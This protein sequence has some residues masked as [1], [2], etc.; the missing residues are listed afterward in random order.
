[1]AKG[2][3][4]LL[5]MAL[6]TVLDVFLGSFITRVKRL[7]MFSITMTV[8]SVLLFSCWQKVAHSPSGSGQDVA[9]PSQHKWAFRDVVRILRDFLQYVS[10]LMSFYEPLTLGN[11]LR[12]RD[13]LSG[14]NYM[15]QACFNE[16]I[17]KFSQEPLLVQQNSKMV[18]QCDGQTMQ[19][20]SGSGDCEIS[21]Y[22]LRNAIQFDVRERTAEMYLTRLSMHQEPLTVRDLLRVKRDLE[23]WGLLSEGLRGCLEFAVQEY[24]KEPFCAQD[25]AQMVVDCG[26]QVVTFASGNQNN[27]INVYDAQDGAIHY[28]I[29]TSSFW[30][31]TARF[32]RGNKGHTQTQG[33]KFLPLE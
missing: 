21:V 12:H 18:I 13:Q 3:A 32:F 25:N 30:V 8:A 7:V 6:Q 22:L 10:V 17:D 4:G 11:L 26:G 24:A 1:M 27:H 20:L 16:A 31:H 29:R 19:F 2:V 14:V 9:V 15:L 33:R 28:R 23:S 5:N